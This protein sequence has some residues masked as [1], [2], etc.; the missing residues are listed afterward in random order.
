MQGGFYALSRY[1]IDTCAIPDPSLFHN[2]GDWA[3]SLAL[4][5]KG[6]QIADFTYGVEID[7]EPRRGIHED[8]WTAPDDP[9]LEEKAW[10]PTNVRGRR[11]DR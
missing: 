9:V 2:D 7:T 6:M 3:T 11:H 8:A 1:A 5:H 4:K 10:L